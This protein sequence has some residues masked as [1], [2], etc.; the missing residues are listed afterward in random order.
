MPDKRECQHAGYT[1]HIHIQQDNVGRYPTKR[2]ECLCP[3]FDNVY[4][5][6]C[7]LQ[8]IGEGVADLDIVVH[9]KDFAHCILR[10]SAYRK[11]ISCSRFLPISAQMMSHRAAWLNKT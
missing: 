1:R 2:F 6:T 8:N 5:I 9:D 3:R 11:D 7:I 4:V 10:C